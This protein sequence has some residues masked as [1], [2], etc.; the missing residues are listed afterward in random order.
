MNSFPRRMRWI[1]SLSLTILAAVGIGVIPGATTAQESS[2]TDRPSRALARDF[3]ALPLTAGG[4]STPVVML[5]MSV[6]EQLHRVAYNDYTDVNGDGVIDATYADNIDY[7]GYFDAYRC[8]SYVGTGAA[9]VFKAT[10]VIA[11]P[12]A[13]PAPP[14]PHGCAGAGEWSGNFLNW[15]SMSRMDI[16]RAGL[17][18]GLRSTDSATKTVLERAYLPPESSA[19]VKVYRGADIGLY[20]PFSNDAE[21]PGVSF[22]NL[23]Y[24]PARRAD[25][26]ESDAPPL[27]RVAR[28]TFPLWSSTELLQCLW[29]EERNA[30]DTPSRNARGL[31][32]QD[33]IVRAEVCSA[34]DAVP[35]ESY[36]RPYP[37]EQPTGYK[38]TGALQN[39]GQSGE[40]RFGMLS[41]S[42]ARPRSGGQ[43][44]R[45][46]GRLAG[47]GSDPGSCAAG[48]EIKLSTGQ[49]CNIAAGTEGI[50]NTLNR[51][52][53]AR[54]SYDA[55][56]GNNSS[57][58]DCE[59]GNEARNA[60][61]QGS[62]GIVANREVCN[63]IGNPI[64]EIY[65]EILRY[66]S[67]E[68]APSTDF[69]SSNEDA[70]YIGGIPTPTWHDPFADD[71]LCA[72]CSILMISSGSNSFDADELP[73][74]SALGLNAAS[75]SNATND[76]GENEGLDDQLVLAGRV[77]DVSTPPDTTGDACKVWAM[78]NLSS[79]RGVCPAQP[80]RE[81]GYQVAGLAHQAWIGDIR[82]GENDI[83]G[84]QRAQTFA[85]N[86]SDQLDGISIPLPGGTVTVTP[87]CEFT[88][89][90]G[91]HTCA[92]V[93]MNP[94]PVPS[95]RS[96]GAFLPYIYGRDVSADGLAGSVLVS[97]HA[98]D[99]GFQRDDEVS[100]VLT[101]CVGAR[102]NLSQ[103]QS[104]PDICWRSGPAVDP[105]CNPDG[106]LT[107]AILENEL[108]IRTEVITGRISPNETV[109]FS[110]SGA[111]DTAS[112][113]TQRLV[114]RPGSSDDNLINGGTSP[115]PA[116]VA[117]ATTVP[118]LSGLAA[119]WGRPQ[120]RLYTAGNGVKRLE[121]PLF[122]AAKY[123]S[124]DSADANDDGLPAASGTAPCAMTSWDRVNNR[125]DD[126]GADCIPD[127]FHDL[128][129]P[130]DF[131]TRLDRLLDDLTERAASGEL[132]LAGAAVSSVGQGAGAV[133]QALYET[134]RS[135]G[136]NPPVSWTGT[137]QALFT[138]RDGNLREDGVTPDGLLDEDDY[139]G[140]PVVQLFFD[141]IAGETRFRRYSAN[142][143]DD[144][145]AFTVV[146]DLRQLRTIW[147]ARR[148]L[149]SLTNTSLA[150]Q[151]PYAN[152]ASSGRH[153]FTFAD[154]DLD[155]RADAEEQVD[156]TEER[157]GSERY[158]VLDVGSVSQAASLINFTRGQDGI[159]DLR[160]RRLNE[161][162]VGEAEVIR[163]GDIVNSS[164]LAVGAPA[165]AYDL[166]YA[167]QSYAAFF[168]QYRTRRNVVYVG[169]NDG[170]LHAFNAGFLPATGVGFQ[171]LPPA[172]DGETAHPLG[173]ELWAYVP[174]NLLP[175]LGWMADP[176]Y[177][178][179]WTMDGSPRAFD[180]RIFAA[181]DVHP[182]GWGT[183][184]V[185]PMRLGGKSIRIPA[186]GGGLAAFSRDGAAITELVTRPAYVILDVTDPEAAPRLIAEFSHEALG[187]TTSN[188]AIAAFAA[189]G[190]PGAP[191]SDIA[192]PDA[193]RWYLMFGNGPQVLSNA[194]SPAAQT[195]KLFR[196]DLKALVD[197]ET[198][199]VDALIDEGPITLIGG[200]AGG[201]TGD[202]VAVDWDLNF[203]ADALYVG[204]SGGTAETPKG[205][206]FKLDFRIGN[207]E[208]AIESGDRMGWRAPA[209]LLELGMPILAAPSVTQ[210][211]NGNEWILGGTGRFLAGDADRQS[212]A[213]QSL[214]GVIDTLP[215][216]DDETAPDFSNFI[217]TSNAV[218]MTNGN[219]TGVTN[220][221]T[222][223]DLRD[224]VAGAGGWRY[225]LRAPVNAPSERSVNRTAL[226]DSLLFATSFTPPDSLCS[227][228]GESRLFGFDFRTGAARSSRP[229]FGTRVVTIGASEEALGIAPEFKGLGTAPTL[230]LN[231]AGS[232]GRGTVT[233]NVQSSTGAIFQ[234]DAD[235]SG[236]IRSNEIDWRETHPNSGP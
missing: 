104:T 85:L 232:T 129:N 12:A 166:L 172:P 95:T 46:L 3:T 148:Q 100:Q 47:N 7:R 14:G 67:G 164:P 50:I 208:S 217:N 59:V 216:S 138:D 186:A 41:G 81:G 221:T 90:F 102:C 190:A 16:V 177:G 78:T 58:D 213:Q 233:I 74:I 209:V 133:Y 1:A 214:F 228:V 119:N 112:S 211:R 115:E 153:I 212:E 156:L 98:S 87:T 61:N 182:N 39:Y 103:N 162:G 121:N 123:G 33:F 210:D 71:E 143:A 63:G 92:L 160:S 155:G 114:V 195:A 127:N 51:L 227:S 235:V 105:R 75:T 31:G 207:D 222:E 124:F 108:L 107:R 220:I 149:S 55:G 30:P 188:P 44:R 37:D 226:L 24:N 25:D 26:S 206:L 234:R 82:T 101:W 76:I 173:S 178:H 54:Y 203:R 38:P 122:Y 86:F 89:G 15:V 56:D 96:R 141:E 170:M 236:A 52:R 120:V 70:R 66:V 144:P 97:W 176:R 20:T 191:D 132:S 111:S 157:F 65:A 40:I 83:P 175:H 230:H 152:L 57:H 6:D 72:E 69:V 11:P 180:V 18:G 23:S 219:L 22:C 136:S 5:G 93:S 179:V 187:F 130:G 163:L 13:P 135:D 77:T 189:R 167:D 196:L 109:G 117:G 140:H 139:A 184:L 154:F 231:P 21:T 43:L 150:V 171:T 110:I 94:G 53:I 68:D 126:P 204:T 200:P 113:G 128:Q 73:N 198:A 88:V 215:L 169:A 28:G 29:N 158:G 205:K 183:I 35:R 60:T 17:Y 79:V 84:R 48:D 161:D 202:P 218:V 229:A 201:F 42:Y 174:F 192:G 64:A 151:R 181:D 106:T 225:N 49:F 134:T 116:P 19:W 199:A 91:V 34:S 165:E 185:V 8:Y 193:D 168:Q 45:N 32:E 2:E 145:A 146:N 10:S 131:I 36:C 224:A 99:Y 9:A 137:L 4:N 62:S 197:G 80:S 27:L 118:T 223:V 142:P 194:E 125:T 147:N 159:A